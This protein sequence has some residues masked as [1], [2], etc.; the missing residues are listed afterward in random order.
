M[1]FRSCAACLCLVIVLLGSCLNKTGK[2]LH[3]EIPEFP[4]TTNDQLVVKKLLER[5]SDYYYN[6]SVLVCRDSA[7]MIVYR[8]HDQQ[9]KHFP[10]TEFIYA[11]GLFILKEG[12]HYF[13]VDDRLFERHPI[14]MIDESARLREIE[15]S[16]YKIYTDTASGNEAIIDSLFIGYFYTKYKLDKGRI[17]FN[18]QVASDD[19]YI[20]TKDT[21]FILTQI[22]YVL[23]RKI[24]PAIV[25]EE[26]E[27]APVKNS[28]QRAEELKERHPHIKET[29][30]AMMRK[31]WHTTG[32]GNH[33]IPSIPVYGEVGYYYYEIDFNSIPGKFKILNG[34]D[35]L[36]DFK[37]GDRSLLVINR[38]E[39]Y[40]LSV[41]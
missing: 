11:N 27:L 1:N 37:T 12:E 30:Y 10:T 23:E 32:G 36:M 3:P 41:K 16:V 39:I 40:S 24:S 29:G 17:P 22:P 14:K 26:R 28:L 5:V 18:Q 33:F 8:F 7:A 15:D 2:D 34:G 9:T 19:Y 35:A 31:A 38:G 13:T 25:K 20:K 4:A 21:D 6:D